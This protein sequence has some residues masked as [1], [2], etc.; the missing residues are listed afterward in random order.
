MSPLDDVGLSI[1]ERPTPE[2][3]AE[4]VAACLKGDVAAQRALFRREYPRVNATIYRILG[5]TREVDD[6]V[7]ETFIAAFRGLAKFRGESRLS[8]WIDRIA[9]RVAFD[10]VRTRSRVPVPLGLAPTAYAADQRYNEFYSS[11][12]R[13]RPGVSVA[14]FN[15]AIDQKHREQVR[16]E[17]SGSFGQS[18]GWSMFAEPWTNDAAGDLRKPLIALFAAVALALAAL[19]IYG[20]MAYAVSQRRKEIA[21]RFALGASRRH[22]IRQLLAEST[23]IALAGGGFALHFLWIAAVVMLVVVLAL[24]FAPR[25]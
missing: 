7:Q 15:A 19:G 23:L 3:E 22:V 5:P 14:Q 8:T 20:V 2:V 25:R 17:G 11:V 21:L 6:L 10:H 4:L 13:L 24:H 9:V 12:V 1:V 18:A 16:R